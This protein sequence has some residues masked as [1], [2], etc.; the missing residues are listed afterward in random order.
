MDA[1][2]Q[3]PHT[4]NRLHKALPYAI[5]LSAVMALWSYWAPWLPHPVAGLVVTGLDLAEYVKFLTTVRS[6]A[7]P[8][9]R[10]GFYLPLVVVS[11]TLSINAYRTSRGVFYARTI[12]SLVVAA[13]AA[14][15]LLP[16]A[17]SP[18]LLLDPEFQLQ[19]AALAFCLFA[20]LLSPMLALLPRSITQSM[21]AV[22][23]T[24]AALLPT[25]QFLRILPT[26]ESLYNRPLQPG[27]GF[28][29]SIASLLT[30]ALLLLIDAWRAP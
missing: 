5:F 16:P 15:N 1:S 29:F 3:A 20:V 4:E 12:G 13:V 30:L 2:I 17:W 21:L 27:Y 18:T 25:A 7:I 8:V 22:L 10:E 11:L 26:M 14:L 23:A 6:G 28:Y 9:W 19:T 24:A